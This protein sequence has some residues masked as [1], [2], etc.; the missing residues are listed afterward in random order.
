[1]KRYLIGLGLAAAL[2]GCSKPTTETAKPEA[3]LAAAAKAHAGGLWQTTIYINDQAMPDVTRVCVDK[4]IFDPMTRYAKESG[5]QDVQRATNAQGYTFSA[6]C[7]QDGVTLNTTGEVKVAA[8]Q[9]TVES[10]STMSGTA[11]VMKMRLD[12]RRVGPCPAGM[13]VEAD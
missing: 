13:A 6:T 8:E 2:A 4:G 11:E 5:C 3:S 9:I 12:S 10:R 1:M 7:S